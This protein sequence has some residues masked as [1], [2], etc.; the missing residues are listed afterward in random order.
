M[1]GFQLA[2]IY[3]HIVL[4]QFSMLYYHDCFQFCGQLFDEGQRQ[5]EHQQLK[6]Y[7]T[8]IVAPFAIKHQNASMEEDQLPEIT[9]VEGRAIIAKVASEV[10]SFAKNSTPEEVRNVSMRN[11]TGDRPL[12]ND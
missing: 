9:A 12:E 8:N 5:A 6:S 1:Q 4:I 3:Q 2:S 10:V 11:G 7:F